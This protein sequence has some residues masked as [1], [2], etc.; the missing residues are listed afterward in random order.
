M[1][2]TDT[3]QQEVWWMIGVLL[4]SIIILRDEKLLTEVGLQ[5]SEH[6]T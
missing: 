2:E 1:R 3:A 4:K 6:S 5:D